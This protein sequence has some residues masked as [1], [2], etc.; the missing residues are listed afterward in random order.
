MMMMAHDSG[1]DSSGDL[2][3]QTIV[4]LRT[5]L[6]SYVRDG[7]DGE[8]LR[9]ALAQAAREAREKGIYPERLLV[10]LKEVWHGLPDSDGADP[11]AQA[12]MLQRVVSICIRHYYE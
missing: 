8:P 1:P 11:A 6:T 9:A 7:T 4:S 12:R 5:S 3:A 2:E 10:R